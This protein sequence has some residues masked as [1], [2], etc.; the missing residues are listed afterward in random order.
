MMPILLITSWILYLSKRSIEKVFRLRK[1]AP[2]ESGGHKV[3]NSTV[4]QHSSIYEGG[5][6]LATYNKATNNVAT[7]K[8]RPIKVLL[9]TN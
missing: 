5:G 9:M 1:R 6:V 8:P 3:V 2:K 7:E 4:N